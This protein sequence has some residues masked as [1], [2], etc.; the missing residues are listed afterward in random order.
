MRGG[1]DDVWINDKEELHIVDYK[2]TSKTTEISLDA[3][4]Q[5]AYKRQV[6]V[7]QWL[8]RQNKFK[9][10]DTAY[11]VY[12]N[13]QTDKEAFDGKLEFEVH[14]LPYKG[15]TDWIEKTLVKI[16][17]CL[18]GSLPPPAPTCEYCEY[19]KLSAQTAMEYRE[20]RKTG[21]LL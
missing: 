9:V 13:G 19:K 12:V 18:D 4:W 21:K 17:E 15:N 16:K 8:F 20:V 5:I 1:I 11:F 3:P 2:A 14:L 7:Y 6:E 10:S